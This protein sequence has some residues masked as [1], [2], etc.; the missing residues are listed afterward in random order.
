MISDYNPS[1]CGVFLANNFH[2]NLKIKLLALFSNAEC[3][4]FI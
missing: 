1:E 2:L 4:T 3:K